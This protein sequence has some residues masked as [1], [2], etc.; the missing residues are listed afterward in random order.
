MFVAVPYDTLESEESP[1]VVQV[2]V[3]VVE[4][5]VEAIEVE[6]GAVLSIVTTRGVEAVEVFPA[7][8]VSLKVIEFDPL[9]SVPVVR[10]NAAPEQVAELPDETPSS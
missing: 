5:V 10:E 7:G 1:V 4:V 3:A 8:S 6:M 2:T 9:A